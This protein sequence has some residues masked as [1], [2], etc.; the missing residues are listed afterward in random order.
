MADEFIRIKPPRKSEIL[1]EFAQEPTFPIAVLEFEIDDNI[2]TPI[3]KIKVN[4]EFYNR[5]KEEYAGN[6]IILYC[7]MQKKQKLR[8]GAF[9]PDMEQSYT[10]LK[11]LNL[12]SDEE[13]WVLKSQDDIKKHLIEGE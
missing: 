5:I 7:N 13:T 1:Y 3:S 4:S 8:F 6:R 12:I 9:T 11:D 10:I 2:E